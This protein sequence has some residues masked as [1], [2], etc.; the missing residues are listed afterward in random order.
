MSYDK[1]EQFN[2]EKEPR[3]ITVSHRLDATTT[4]QEQFKKHHHSVLDR[5]KSTR[6]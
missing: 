6:R 5:A 2:L 1:V 4:M 3:L